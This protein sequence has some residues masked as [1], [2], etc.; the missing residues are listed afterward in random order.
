VTVDR[1]DLAK[2]GNRF[3]ARS[4]RSVI[5]V[6]ASGRSARG[7][8][9]FKGLSFSAHWKGQ[10][11]WANT[12]GAVLR[13]P[14]PVQTGSGSDGRS[15]APPRRAAGLFGLQH[16]RTLA[17]DPGRT[18]SPNTGI[19]GSFGFSTAIAVLIGVVIIS[20]TMYTQRPWPDAGL[21]VMRAIG[22]RRLD[23]AVVV[24]S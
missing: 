22:G 13:H 11:D 18:T 9:V 1:L 24:I 20:L 10:A 14:G 12:T 7:P 4:R 23:I 2:L 8:G 6:S 17:A 16:S 21:R 15:R 19:G 3:W 5:S